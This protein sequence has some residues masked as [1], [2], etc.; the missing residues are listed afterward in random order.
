MC[1]G[2]FS[3]ILF[4]SLLCCKSTIYFLNRQIFL[5]FFGDIVHNIRKERKAAW[6][7]KMQKKFD[8][9]L[10]VYECYNSFS[11]ISLV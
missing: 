6:E 11:L 10:T 8:A 3:F 1:G 4:Y 2:F 5:I 9:R 7:E